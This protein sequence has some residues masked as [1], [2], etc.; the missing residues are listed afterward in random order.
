MARQE[1]IS[2]I[3]TRLHQASPAGFAIA[4]HVKY[5]A[6]RYLFQSYERDWLDTYSRKGLVLHDPT[7]RWGFEHTGA[8]RWSDLADDDD[9]GVLEQ[10]AAHGLRFGV[11]V[12]YT[13]EGSRS[14]ASFARSDREPTDA[15]ISGLAADLAELH[16]L[17]ATAEKL[18]PSVHETLKQLS[19]YL[20]HG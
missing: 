20:T 3:L 11:C 19:I 17:T 15:E 4:L 18:S 14:M 7:V 10:A 2:A 9:K 6:P 12:A 16:G 8:I 5:T 1:K 13:A